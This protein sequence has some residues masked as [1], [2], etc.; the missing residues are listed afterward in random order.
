MSECRTPEEEVDVWWGSY[1][2]RTML[3]SFVAC[4]VLTVLIDLVCW[5]ALPRY[6]LRWSV[7]ILS[8]LL[9][10]VQTL[11][12]LHHILGYNYRLTNR[13]LYV[14]HG[15]FAPETAVADLDRIK[16]VKVGANVIQR[17]LGVGR[18]A[19]YVDDD[20]QLPL[21]LDGV[22][23]PWHVREMIARQAGQVKK[24]LPIQSPFVG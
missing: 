19:V 9:W 17:R 15:L 21:I 11:R 14:E 18:V 4:L 7:I 20:A 1:A 13:R 2:A 24:S 8:G 23:H 6:L 22:L 10:L 3:P 5:L 16:A 12:W